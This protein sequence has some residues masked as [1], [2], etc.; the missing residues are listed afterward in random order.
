MGRLKRHDGKPVIF[1]IYP[2]EDLIARMVPVFREFPEVEC[3]WL[4]GSQAKRYRLRWDSDVDLMIKTPPLAVRR[5]ILER[6]LEEAIGKVVFTVDYDSYIR[7]GAGRGTDIERT[8]ILIYDR[9]KE[10]ERNQN[11]EVEHG[12]EVVL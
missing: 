12:T 9:D 11:Q 1:G 2:L 5:D 8:K 6:T 4:Y 3:V 7:S 10:R